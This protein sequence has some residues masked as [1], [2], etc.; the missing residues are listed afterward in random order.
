MS[1]PSSRCPACA[2]NHWGTDQV[3]KDHSISGESFTLRE[4][5]D[6]HIKVTVDAP[7]PSEIAP[8]YASEDYI[9]HSDVQHDLKDKLYH[10]ARGIMLRR[11]A[12][13]I[14]PH[15]ATEHAKLLDIGCGTGYFLKHMHDRGH[16][17][18]GL[19]PDDDARAI[20][21][22]QGDF[23]VY[24]SD[25]L[26]QLDGSY[27]AITM[28]HVLEHVHDLDGYA[29]KIRS[30]LLD[31]GLWVIAV[32]NH[33][34]RDADHYGTDWAAYDVPRHL[35]HFSPRSIDAYVERHDMIVV[36]R[37]RMIMDPFYVSLLSSGY[38]RGKPSYLSAVWTGLRSSMRSFVSVEESSSIVYFVKKK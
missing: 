16:T 12:A 10:R 29:S 15:L 18:V 2:A 30:L 21:D 5:L 33:T 37:K 23:S 6:C 24:P 1:G 11:K 34:S 14:E 20:A 4:C 38:R 3:V 13:W 17:V 7:G 19:E 31:H 22:K 26:A 35:W 32:P 8:Y 25:H 9:S 27:D 28:W 36:D